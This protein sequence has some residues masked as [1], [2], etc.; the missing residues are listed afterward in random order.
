MESNESSLYN[1]C[2]VRRWKNFEN[3][4]TF[5]EVMGKNSVLFFDSWGTCSTDRLTPNCFT[6]DI[7][8]INHR[9]HWRFR[10]CSRKSRKS[11][12]RRQFIAQSII[13]DHIHVDLESPFKN[14]L[15]QAVWADEMWHG[16]I[17]LFT[18]PM[19]Y[20]SVLRP[21]RRDVWEHARLTRCA[22]F[23]LCLE[24]NSAPLHTGKNNQELCCR[25]AFWKIP[26]HAIKIPLSITFPYHILVPVSISSLQ[27]RRFQPDHVT[28]TFDLLFE[29]T[30][31]SEEH[32]VSTTF[33]FCYRLE[34][35]RRTDRQTDR[36]TNG[37]ALAIDE[38]RIITPVC[39]WWLLLLLQLRRLLTSALR[40]LAC[41]VWLAQLRPD[42]IFEGYQQTLFGS[43]W[44]ELNA[45][46][47]ATTATRLPFDCNSTAL[48]PFDDLRHDG[49]P[50]YVGCCTAAH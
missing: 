13:V 31:V 32:S 2:W 8:L 34:L 47:A 48:R 41:W 30:H 50:A 20:L 23:Q 49:R 4:S 43:V 29:D 39:L 28:L 33:P 11:S 1:H 10:K 38:G 9:K 3:R 36:Q 16:I 42:S 24:I 25:G 14:T 26:Q 27:N 22:A 35:D 19:L 7:S 17:V 15:P 37:A 18:T 21:R 6:E 5:A 44:T 40:S 12:A 46:A 45:N